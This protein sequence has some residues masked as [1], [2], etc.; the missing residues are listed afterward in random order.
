MEYVGRVSRSDWRNVASDALEATFF[1]SPVWADLVTSAYPDVEVN[2]FGWRGS[3]GIDIV[4]P[5]FSCANVVT[6][7]GFEFEL[8]LLISSFANTYGGPVSRA[9]RAVT[10]AELMEEVDTA[11]PFGRLHVHTTPLEDRLPLGS[12][13]DCSV[14]EDFTQILPLDRSFD[15]VLEVYSD[16]RRR[17]VAAGRKR[18]VTVREADSKADFEAYYDAYQASL[19][20][21]DDPDRRYPWNLFESA[22]EFSTD[23]PEHVKLWL[24]EVDGELAAGILVFYWNRHAVYWHGAGYEELFEYRPNDLLH[25]EVIRDCID[26]GYRYYDFSPSGG[27]EGVVQFKDGFGPERWPTQTIKK[28]GGM[29][30]T[31][32]H[33]YET[34][35]NSLPVK[36]RLGSSNRRYPRPSSK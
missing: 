18:G 15:E 13:P 6:V 36:V 27:H 1:H 3:D 7:R 12:D 22:Y 8:P 17:A 5:T 19:E 28:E 24:A 4:F 26:S 31:L 32:R 11:G 21:W 25:T 10:V 29:I 35:G 34:Y 23:Y 20:R 9:D 2:T 30:K 16:G 14:V 33:L